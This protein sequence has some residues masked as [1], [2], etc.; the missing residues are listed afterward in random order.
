MFCSKCGK[1]IKPNEKFCSNCGA[2]IGEDNKT[3]KERL[4]SKKI[5]LIV[6]GIAVVAVVVFI[7][8]VGNAGRKEPAE[9]ETVME[10]EESGTKDDVIVAETEMTSVTELTEEDASVVRK[11]IVE[12]YLA[13]KEFLDRYD[14]TTGGNQYALVYIGTEIPQL[15][16]YNDYSRVVEL[17]SYY[18]GK[19]NSV[20]L[21]G[22]GGAP[23]VY[24]IENGNKVCVDNTNMMGFYYSTIYTFENGEFIENIDASGEWDF[25]NPEEPSFTGLWNGE[26]VSQ[27]VYDQRLKENFDFS[28]AIC[29]SPYSEREEALTTVTYG[30]KDEV[31]EFLFRETID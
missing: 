3:A 24:Y 20:Q 14:E 17:V 30:G 8:G 18:D 22:G 28:Q 12:T 25:E 11:E 6:V 15:A 9:H 4:D 10:T 21:G 29:F 1:E 16:I 27:E 23:T 31:A 5:W 2:K 26:A 7:I 13:Y 19:L